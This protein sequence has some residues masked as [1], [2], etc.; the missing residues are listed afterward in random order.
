MVGES[1]ESRKAE[2]LLRGILFQ[3]PGTYRTY[4]FTILWPIGLMQEDIWL[5]G[6]KELEGQ[7]PQVL[8]RELHEPKLARQLERLVRQLGRLPGFP[9][10]AIEFIVHEDGQRETLDDRRAL[11]EHLSLGVHGL[12]W[13][14]VR[15]RI[16][17]PFFSIQ[18][19]RALDFGKDPVEELKS[20]LDRYL[21]GL[22]RGESVHHPDWIILGVNGPGLPNYTPALTSEEQQELASSRLLGVPRR[23]LELRA[24]ATK[25]LKSS[26]LEPP[27]S[28]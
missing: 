1:P 6:E 9:P 3:Y 19:Q 27:R 7:I 24:I 12:V 10:V 22:W 23:S 14:A 4:T 13:I 11:P 28:E 2:D 18:H 20:Y 25:L 8:N 17:G 26:P 21:I 5:H 15:A 16:T